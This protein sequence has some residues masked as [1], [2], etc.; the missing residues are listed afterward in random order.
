MTAA[1]VLGVD[2]C[3]MEGFSP[4]DY[5]EAL[6]L[7][8]TGYQSVV[9]CALG[10]RAASDKYATAPKVRFAVETLIQKI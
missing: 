10:H 1:A 9:A 6:G 5:D 7:K 3:P 2:A 4:A 8:G